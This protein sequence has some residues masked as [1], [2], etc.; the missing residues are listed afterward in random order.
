M[1]PQAGNFTDYTLCENISNY[2]PYDI[3]DASSVINKELDKINS[4][5]SNHTSEIKTSINELDEEWGKKFVSVN[6][7]GLNFVQPSEME[8]IFSEI[9]NDSNDEINVKVLLK[10][11]KVVLQMLRNMLKNYKIIWKSIK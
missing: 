9:D 8:N 5:K 7:S 2:I 6:D 3:G 1:L 4:L 11:L 10:I